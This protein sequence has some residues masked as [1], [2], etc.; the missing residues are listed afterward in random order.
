MLASHWLQ[1]MAVILY[2]VATA[3]VLN[4]CD[5][6][7]APAKQ[8]QAKPGP[9][10]PT[11]PAGQPPKDTSQP[12]LSE[13]RKRRITERQA[14]SENRVKRRVRYRAL[15]VDLAAMIKTDLPAALQELAE[16]ATRY[17]NK[18]PDLKHLEKADQWEREAPVK[19]AHATARRY[20]EE[21]YRI[22]FEAQKERE[23]PTLHDKTDIADL[24]KR[25]AA[26][27]KGR[28]DIEGFASELPLFYGRVP[29]SLMLS[30]VD[31]IAQ[32]VLPKDAFDPCRDPQAA[33]CPKPPAPPTA[34]LPDARAK[35]TPAALDVSAA[36]L[37]SRPAPP[38]PSGPRFCADP[39]RLADAPG[40]LP[41]REGPTNRARQKEQ[42]PPG[43]CALIATGRH[44]P[45]AQILGT[46]TWLEIVR[47]RTA[48]TGW[49][50]SWYLR[51]ER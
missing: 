7:L 21:W 37:Q 26:F 24:T 13:D 16:A 45:D 42:I 35:A 47:A 48:T 31:A 9:A 28:Q 22:D 40:G 44:Q 10:L 33:T 1:A 23:G 43:E 30:A 46:F 18:L 38:R 29:Q 36:P 5:R 20:S 39:R 49:V 50:N 41:L 4:S 3:W 11:A 15:E 32:L 8:T 27:R 14:E 19:Q 17:R 34:A 2:V 51:R 6:S 12:E 25:I